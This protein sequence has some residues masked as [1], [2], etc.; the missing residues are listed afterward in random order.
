MESA[1]WS[2]LDDH[3]Y[4]RTKLNLVHLRIFFTCIKWNFC[5][6]F[7]HLPYCCSKVILST[8]ATKFLLILNSTIWRFFFAGLLTLQSSLKLVFCGLCVLWLIHSWKPIRLIESD[9]CVQCSRFFKFLY[10][11]SYPLKLDWMIVPNFR[12]TKP[13]P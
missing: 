7:A 10:Y 12:F 13:V 2:A 1:A 9:S 8:C 5:I 11:N 3:E 6:Y 4:T